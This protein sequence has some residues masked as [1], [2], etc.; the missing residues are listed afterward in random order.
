MEDRWLDADSVHVL[1]V[2]GPKGAG[3]DVIRE[4]CTRAGM[5]EVERDR[6][7]ALYMLREW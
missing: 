1:F 2:Q 5:E 6:L 7:L 4:V 3:S